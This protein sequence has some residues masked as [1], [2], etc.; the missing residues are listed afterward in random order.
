[1]WH[2]LSETRPANTI[3]PLMHAMLQCSQMQ[4]LSPWVHASM[5]APSCPL[6]MLRTLPV[7]AA[8]PDLCSSVAPI[9]PLVTDLLASG[10][11]LP[12][13]AVLL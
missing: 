3:L 9:H 11:G 6:R 5:H 4:A 7:V 2:F 10:W 13:H 8:L 12:Q 1:M